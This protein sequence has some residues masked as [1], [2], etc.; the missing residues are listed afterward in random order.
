V[1]HIRKNDS[2]SLEGIMASNFKLIF[3]QKKDSLHLKLH[4]DFDGNSALELINALK[5]TRAGLN[6]ILVDTNDLTLIHSFGKEVFH[7]NIRIRKRRYTRLNFV[8]KYRH[9]FAA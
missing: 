6:N 8:G 2:T 5:E 4:G 3:H 7:R 1:A 9:H